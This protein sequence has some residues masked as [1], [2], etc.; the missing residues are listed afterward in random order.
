[1]ATICPAELEGYGELSRMRRSTQLFALLSAQRLAGFAGIAGFV[2]LG[3][4]LE[5]VSELNN[6]LLGLLSCLRYSTIRG[7]PN[8]SAY[9]LHKFD[10]FAYH[11]RLTNTIF[12]FSSFGL[13]VLTLSIVTAWLRLG[14]GGCGDCHDYIAWIENSLDTLFYE[15]RQKNVE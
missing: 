7:P 1:M 14:R 11:L 4:Y 10:C 5:V 12:C 9:E 15:N 8:L 6:N 13:T 3:S 2:T